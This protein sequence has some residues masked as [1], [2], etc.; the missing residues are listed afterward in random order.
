VSRPVLEA[1]TDSPQQDE[2][3]EIFPSGYPQPNLDRVTR[4]LDSHSTFRGRFLFEEFTGRVLSTWPKCAQR[5]W[6]DA[7]DLVLTVH[8]QRF[9]GLSKL[10][11]AVVNAAV[12]G[13]E[14]AT[15]EQRHQMARVAPLG[16]SQPLVHFDASGIWF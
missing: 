6:T 13:C 12:G 3:L 11:V 9:F 15:R 2:E 1:V 4:I 8:L 14:C 5:E 16:S 7:D 10:T